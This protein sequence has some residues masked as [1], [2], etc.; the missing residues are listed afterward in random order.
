LYG[1]YIDDH[2]QVGAVLFV[3]FYTV[4]C[5]LFLP[6]SLFTIGAGFL[7]KPFPFALGIVILGDILGTI[8]SFLL[9]R[10]IFYSWVKQTMS[11]HPKFGALDQ[12]IKDDGMTKPK[13]DVVRRIRES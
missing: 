3:T 10:Y 11:K 4:A 1:S 5:W 9:G 7:F 13:K 6:G 2:K 12:V 8:G